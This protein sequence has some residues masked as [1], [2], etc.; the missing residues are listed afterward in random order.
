MTI[1][2]IKN[3]SAYKKVLADSFGG[4]MYNL[5]NQGKYD[6]SEVLQIWSN[7]TP[8]EQSSADGI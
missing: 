2:H 3:H 1:E 6:A 4:I 7:L 8:S 5:A